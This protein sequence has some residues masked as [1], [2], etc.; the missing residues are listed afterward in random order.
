[1]GLPQWIFAQGTLNPTEQMGLPRK[2][3]SK[4]CFFFCD[5][6]LVYVGHAGSIFVQILCFFF[7]IAESLRRLEI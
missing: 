7:R 5:G 2:D 6:K 4:M 1:M 3:P